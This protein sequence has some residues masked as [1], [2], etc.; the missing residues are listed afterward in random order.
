MSLTPDSIKGIEAGHDKLEPELVNKMLNNGAK[1]SENLKLREEGAEVVGEGKFG[2]VWEMLLG[3][4]L[5]VSKR[6]V[7]TLCSLLGCDDASAV[8]TVA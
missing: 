4:L 7:R 2:T 8:H 1:I 6:S 5:V 3:K